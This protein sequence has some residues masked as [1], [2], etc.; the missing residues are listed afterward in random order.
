[1][2]IFSLLFNIDLIKA[3][4]K[5]KRKEEASKS[6]RKNKII[7][8]QMTWILYAENPKDYTQS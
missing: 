4:K 8:L 3:T 1:M 5:K 6:E 2:P 7:C